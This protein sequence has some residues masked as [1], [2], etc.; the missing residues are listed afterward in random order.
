[1]TLVFQ[2][3]LIVMS[4]YGLKLKPLGGGPDGGGLLG[5]GFDGGGSVGGFVVPPEQF[6]L[7]VQGSPLPA[8]PLWIDG[9]TP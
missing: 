6:P 9:S 8:P 4:L 1:M 3:M 2:F 5:G 7:N